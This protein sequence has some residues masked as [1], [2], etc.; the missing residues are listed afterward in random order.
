LRND[1]HK[2]NSKDAGWLAVVAVDEIAE[3]DAAQ[4]TEQEWL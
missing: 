3:K 1:A 2:H 4:Q